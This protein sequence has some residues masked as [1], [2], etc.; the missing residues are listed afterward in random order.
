M[1][2]SASA[3][4]RLKRTFLDYVLLLLVVEKIIQHIVVSLAFYFNWTNIRSTVVVQPTILL[5]LG[6]I[7]A[8]TFC[9]ALYG[10]L[11]RTAWSLNL[12]LGL[13]VFDILGEFIAQGTIVIAIT[14]SF[15]AAW[16]L[17][18]LAVLQKRRDIRPG[19][20]DA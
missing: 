7:V 2:S 5:V 3:S 10:L 13:A 11:R 19:P 17:L 6:S 4:P 16:L 18:A 12:I 14:F 15:I 20:H 8:V 1:S 9:I